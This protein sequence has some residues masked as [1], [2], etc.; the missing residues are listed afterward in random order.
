[1]QNSGKRVKLTL[2]GVGKV[3]MQKPAYYGNSCYG[4]RGFSVDYCSDCK[5]CYI[6]DVYRRK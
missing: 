4:T 2:K 5:K 6:E 3:K 1:M